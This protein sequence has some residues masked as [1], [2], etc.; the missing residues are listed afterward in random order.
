MQLL[1]V[2]VQYKLH[3]TYLFLLSLTIV[4]YLTYFKIHTTFYHKLFTKF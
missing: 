1:N 2:L 3:V 4:K